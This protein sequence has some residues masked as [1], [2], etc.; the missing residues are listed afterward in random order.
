MKDEDQRGKYTLTVPL[1]ASAIEDFRPDQPVKVVAQGGAG[2]S[3]Q[4]VELDE[5]GQGVAEFVFAD[6]PGTLR[7]AIG[8]QDASD[9]ELLGMQTIG[10]DVTPRQWGRQN[11][12]RLPALMI[13]P[14]YWHW[15]RR[16]CR[17]FTIRGR[18]VC[19]NGNPV[20]GAKVCAYDTDLWWWWCSKQLVGCATTDATGAFEI[21][22]RWCCGWW[23][24]YW[25]QHRF[26]HLEPSVA[27]RLLPV[28][29][30]EL[31][32]RKPP[33]PDPRP[34]LAI[35]EE[36][37]SGAQPT[38]RR[39][40][41]VREP[42]AEAALSRATAA[43]MLGG[44]AAQIG[45]PGETR[46]DPSIL[47]NLGDL[48]RDR[49][50]V[51]PEIERLRLWPWWPWRP[52]SDCTPDIIFRATQNCH[53][54][55]A[56]IVDEQCSDTRWN[57]S[58]NTTVTL[59]ANEAACC[60]PGGEGC[61]EGNCVALT[62]ACDSLVATIG[63]NLGAPAG[64]IGYQNP[65]AG[66][67]YS[68]RPF[69]GRVRLDGT[70]EC[71]D[72]VD[73][74][75]F[76]WTTTPAN[77]ASW[78]AMPPAAAG[79][80]SRTYI[81]FSTLTFPSVSFTTSL[82]S[83]RN[84]FETLQHY[85]A[86]H[87]PADWGGNRLWVGNRDVLMNWLTENNFGDGTYYLRVKGWNAVGPGPDNLQNERVLPVC[88]SGQDNF[89]VLRLDNRFVGPGPTCPNGHPGGVGTVHTSTT[90]PDTG[91]LAVKIAHADGSETEVGACGKTV[92]RDTD[93]LLIDFMAHDPAG[94]LAEYTLHATYGVNEDNDLLGLA[95]MSLAPSSA[96][97]P[98]PAAVQVGPTY[99]D[100]LVAIPAA[101]SP[102]WHGG[103]IRYKVRAVDAFPESCCYQLELRAIKRTIVN[104][105]STD[106]RN[107]SEYSF[108]VEV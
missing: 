50:P 105:G 46:F 4:I 11:Q 35:F 24:W 12:L 37:L 73:F 1:D 74:Y 22:F 15:W 18:I 86:T 42:G 28:L 57:I 3:S 30:R 56:V 83:G 59:V 58:T 95:G 36:L 81:D 2:T 31:K 33:I 61:L 53:G 108:M 97:A 14:Y 100:A 10:V 68:D 65:G 106:H 88:G 55:D 82:K 98:V 89:V 76:E 80:F 66:T 32:L 26:W 71:M 64:P 16:W 13:A 91:F 79:G 103:A 9:D 69:A 5:R 87:P 67:T 21:T 93:V 8:P 70:T 84:V 92:I 6:R 104:C 52:W 72:G 27:D 94:H 29:Q 40:G 49:L 51:I 44:A 99:A 62:H 90:E 23:P 75:E 102:T 63:G 34:D 48:L 54:D 77:P 47:E 39:S 38:M 60:I 19:P 107:Y 17:T 45:R 7:V 101:A 20:P 41:V 85:E 25:W 78:A 96:P 43:R